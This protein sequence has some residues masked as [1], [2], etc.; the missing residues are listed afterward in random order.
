MNTESI[1]FRATHER[2]ADARAAEIAEWAKRE[3]ESARRSI[4]QITRSDHFWRRFGR[5]VA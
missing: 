1:E 5:E 3:F 4:G 2:I